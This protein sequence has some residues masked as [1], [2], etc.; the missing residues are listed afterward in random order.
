MIFLFLYPQYLFA[1][2]PARWWEGG[3]DGEELSN[4][5][6]LE[7]GVMSQPMIFCNVMFECQGQNQA[8]DIANRN[9]MCNQGMQ[10]IERL[11]HITRVVFSS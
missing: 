5:W 11:Y 7:I 8:S 9:L 4:I 1:S 10:N 3:Y 2:V 6:K